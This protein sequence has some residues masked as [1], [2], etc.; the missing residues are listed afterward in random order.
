MTWA[1]DHRSKVIFIHVPKTGGR[2]LF[3]KHEGAFSNLGIT[4]YHHEPLVRLRDQLMER[5][6]RYF[7]FGMV[8]NPY[9]RM[10]SIYVRDIHTRRLDLSLSEWLLATIPRE[11]KF[12]GLHPQWFWLCDERGTLLANHVG[13]YED[14]KESVKI[15]SSHLGIPYPKVLPFV[16]QTCWRKPWKEYFNQEALDYMN[17]YHSLDF[18]LF[19]YEKCEYLKA[20]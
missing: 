8:R 19:G 2:S 9:D 4:K 16:G 3:H 18:E 6:D 17:K 1:I 11:G 13:R 15:L 10:A 7:K 20:A 14:Y 5:F 12:P